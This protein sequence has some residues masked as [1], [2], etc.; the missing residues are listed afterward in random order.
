MQIRRVVT[1]HDEQ[2]RAVVLYDGVAENV[3]SQRAKQERCLIW[4][5]DTLPAVNE[6][7][8]DR[9]DLAVGTGLE[10][11]SMFGIVT[12]EPGCQPHV[13]RTS[14]IDY[15]L[16][17]AGQM[18]LELDGQEV[19]LKAGDVFVQRGTIHSW[20]NRGSEPCVMAVVMIDA[21]PVKA[22]GKLLDRV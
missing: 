5:T 10:G 11:G 13:H 8:A 21:E 4:T 1:G 9:G 2:G 22:G 6:G 19:L 20:I 15:G 12:L 16:I 7:A 14:T 3:I 18:H 17:L